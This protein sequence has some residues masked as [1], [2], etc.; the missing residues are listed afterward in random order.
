[1]EAPRKIEAHL[2]DL[3]GQVGS[4]EGRI[5]REMLLQECLHG[6][7]VDLG[8]IFEERPE[9]LGR[10]AD[11]VDFQEPQGV[12]ALDMSVQKRLLVDQ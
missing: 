7:G 11:L 1:M 4:H 3:H 9:G 6:L 8:D 12:F 2:I 5:P 10:V